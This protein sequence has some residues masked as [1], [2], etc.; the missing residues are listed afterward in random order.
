MSR[1]LS[2][3]VRRLPA[4]EARVVRMRIDVSD[5]TYAGAVELWCPA[6]QVVVLG[7]GLAAFSATAPEPLAT[8][9]EERE[10]PRTS[11]CGS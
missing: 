1:G 4:N 11:P 8:S 9:S 3:G 5:G 7:R 10:E 2:I 6:E